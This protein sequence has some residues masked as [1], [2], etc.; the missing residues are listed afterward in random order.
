MDLFH[1]PW[2]HRIWVIQEFVMAERILFICGQWTCSLDDL[3][4]VMLT[5]LDLGIMGT[6][7]PM[8]E[9]IQTREQAAKG[10]AQIS[11]MN[12]YRNSR[13]RSGEIELF[14]ILE[15]CRYSLATDPKRLPIW[16]FGTDRGC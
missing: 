12:I 15:E 4:S 10:Y 13:Q 2:F 6:A 9:P 3:E 14:R 1:R 16:S 11:L 7:V 5:A 8:D